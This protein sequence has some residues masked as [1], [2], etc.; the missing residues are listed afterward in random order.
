MDYIV[1]DWSGIRTLRKKSLSYGFNF[2]IIEIGAVRVSDDRKT[3]VD[4]FQQVIK[5]E[6]SRN[7]TIRFRK[8]PISLKKS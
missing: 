3:I 1:M 6:F 8:L 4:S 7:F 2:E 5:P